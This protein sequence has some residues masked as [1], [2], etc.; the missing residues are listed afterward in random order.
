MAHLKDKTIAEIVSEDI[1]TASVFKKY[2]I[3][4][5]CG[6]G[7]TVENACKKANVNLDDVLYDLQNNIPN[8]AVPTLNFNDWT[9]VFLV[10]YIV[11]V[12]HTYV[13]ANLDIID[14]FSTKVAT[15]HGH[16]AIETIEINELFTELKSELLAHLDKE[17]NILFPAIKLKANNPDY[18][19]D[20]A[21]ISIL[22]DE[23]EHAGDIV[24]K[25]TYLSNN[26][27]PPDW[28]CNTFKALYFKLDEFINDLY[29][30]IHLENNILFSKIK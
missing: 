6:G 24:K 30:H 12:H 22:E 8:N 2:Q 28:A 13:K 14:E 5:C 16:H 11:N 29:Q 17:E 10:D 19:F 20:A 23:H 27:T 18:Q 4:F 21:V 3:D 9:P 7:K 1:S 25:I 26:F 15:V